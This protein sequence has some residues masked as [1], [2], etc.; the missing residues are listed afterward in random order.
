MILMMVYKNRS[1]KVAV[2]GPVFGPPMYIHTYIHTY[3]VYNTRNYRIP[4]VCPSFCILKNT[5]K[6][7][8]FRKLDLFPSSDTSLFHLRTENRSSFPNVKFSSDFQNTVQ[9]TK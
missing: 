5:L 4:G 1:F 3:M 2:I 6:N 7:V 9:W 8:T